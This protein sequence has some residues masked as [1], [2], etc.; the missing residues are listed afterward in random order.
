MLAAAGS[1]YFPA[2]RDGVAVPG[3]CQV[4]YDFRL[5]DP[6]FRRKSWPS[7]PMDRPLVS[8]LGNVKTQHTAQGVGYLEIRFAD[9]LVRGDMPVALFRDIVAQVQAHL[10]NGEAVLRVTNYLS[11]PRNW[12]PQYVWSWADEGDISVDCGMAPKDAKALGIASTYHFD[13]M[14]GKFVL[15]DL[16]SIYR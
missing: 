16:A 13:E 4:S 9:V 6:R 8:E 14:G 1:R 3:V 15:S 2:R 11:L 10:R 12:D 7:A 5:D